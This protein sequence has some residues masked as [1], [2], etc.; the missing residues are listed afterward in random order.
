MQ[1]STDE[2]RSCI[3]GKITLKQNSMGVKHLESNSLGQKALI[4]PGRSL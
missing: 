4:L 3:V 2:Y 1:T